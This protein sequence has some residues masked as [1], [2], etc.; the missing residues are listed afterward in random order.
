[1]RISALIICL[2]SVGAVAN[3][4]PLPPII[5]VSQREAEALGF[6]IHL[7][8][9]LSFDCVFSIRVSAPETIGKLGVRSVSGGLLEGNEPLFAPSGAADGSDYHALVSG[10]VLR[11]VVV[12][13]EYIGDGKG[14]VYRVGFGDAD[15]QCK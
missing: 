11:Q 6:E 2:S 9:D 10:Q 5:D 13:A 14:T 8:R 1:M 15:G 3:S 7:T 4:P 12:I